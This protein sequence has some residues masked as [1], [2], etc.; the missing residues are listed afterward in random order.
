MYFYTYGW[1]LADNVFPINSTPWSIK[2]K[3]RILW[4]TK[5]LLNSLG[6]S[7][8][9]QE[10][11]MLIELYLHHNLCFVWSCRPPYDKREDREEQNKAE[12]SK[13]D[14]ATPRQP[15]VLIEIIIRPFFLDHIALRPTLVIHPLPVSLPARRWPE[16]PR[17]PAGRGGPG[18]ASEWRVGGWLH[19]AV[20]NR[21]SLHR[22]RLV[23][24]VRV[25]RRALHVV[26]RPLGGS[27][28]RRGG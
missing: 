7:K 19:G 17:E 2:L 27:R 18:V 11:P 8:F 15:P 28:R 1:W 5:Y 21:G 26:D 9:N 6:R 24:I 4:S 25:P 10:E 12:E 14:L 20:V 3:L 22:R 13:N 23:A 16:R